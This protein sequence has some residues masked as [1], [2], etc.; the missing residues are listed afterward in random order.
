MLELLY[1]YA[2]MIKTES[3]SW[4]WSSN[5]FLPLGID[6]AEQY[7]VNIDFSDSDVQYSNKSTYIRDVLAVRE[8]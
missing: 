4:Y 8:F 5:Q 3:A 2:D 1:N 6:N 7:A